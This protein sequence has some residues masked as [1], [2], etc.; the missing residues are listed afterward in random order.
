MDQ[1]SKEEYTKQLQSAP[2]QDIKEEA[3]KYGVV[4]ASDVKWKDLIP[5]IVD[6]KF[7]EADPEVFLEEDEL[8]EE[9]KEFLEAD[10]VSEEE[11]V[12]EVKE[13]FDYVRRND[14]V[15]VCPVCDHPVRT[16]FTNEKICPVAKPQ[17]PRPG[18][19]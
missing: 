15:F 11:T 7:K 4:K 3:D 1:L 14:G 5:T 8:T 17:C 16:G 9:D 2:W 13:S 18:V 12:L 6:A 10:L 19:N